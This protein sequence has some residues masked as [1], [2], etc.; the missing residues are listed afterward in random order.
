MPREVQANRALELDTRKRIFEFV[1]KHPGSHMREIGRETDIPLGTLEY[2]LRYLERAGLFVTRED[3]RFT[4]Y[5]VEGEMGRQEKT[6]LAVLRQEMPRRIAAFLLEHPGSSH[7]EILENFDV[8]ASTLSFHL[9]KLLRDDVAS[10]EKH[11]RENLYWINDADL[12]ARVLIRHK[13]SFLD[14]VI[15]RFAHVWLGME[16]RADDG[17]G[18]GDEGPGG[19]VV[20]R[21]GGVLAV[22]LRVAFPFTHAATPG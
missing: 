1:R 10:Q 7:K 22:L 14:D 17:K 16:P 11:G 2:H 4:R 19:N 21:G 13:E 15:D 20:V 6:I 12:V 5:F 9:K 8:S 3:G 18:D